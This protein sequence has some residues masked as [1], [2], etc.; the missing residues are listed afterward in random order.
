MC[1][2]ILLILLLITSVYADCVLINYDTARYD[3]AFKS[4][5]PIVAYLRQETNQPWFRQLLLAWPRPA[6]SHYLNQCWDIVN[7][8]LRD[9]LRCNFNWNPH[10]FFKKRHSK[11]SSGKLRPCCLGL[12]VLLMQ[13]NN[14]F[15]LSLKVFQKFQPISETVYTQSLQHTHINMH[16]SLWFVVVSTRETDQIL[17]EWYATRGRWETRAFLVF[18]NFGDAIGPNDTLVGCVKSHRRNWLIHRN[19]RVFCHVARFIRYRS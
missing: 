10:F 19:L 1:C 16:M 8:T 15:Q 12:N 4:L 17:S 7:W 18:I 6:P 3:N 14:C 11:M 13:Y 2:H 9:K 5:R